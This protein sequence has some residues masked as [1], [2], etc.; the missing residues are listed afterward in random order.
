MVRIEGDEYTLVRKGNEVVKIDP[1]GENFPSYRRDHYRQGSA[2]FKT[3]K[4]FVSD[5]LIVW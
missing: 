3:V 2:R 4:R 1:P 5:V